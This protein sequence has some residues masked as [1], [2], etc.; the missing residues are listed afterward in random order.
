MGGL[1]ANSEVE[2]GCIPKTVGLLA[3]FLLVA[4]YVVAVLPRLSAGKM[5]VVA[6][7]FIGIGLAVPWIA[8]SNYQLLFDPIYPPVTFAA[9]YVGGTALAF[10][11]ALFGLE[12]E[13]WQVRASYDQKPYRRAVMETYGATCVA[14]PDYPTAAYTHGDPAGHHIRPIQHAVAGC[15]PAL[16]GTGIG[17]LEI[18][19]RDIDELAGRAPRH[20]QPGCHRY[21]R[22]SIQQ[23]NRC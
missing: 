14:S 11:C 9:I 18:D 4:A 3:M 17:H 12:C 21:Q 20:R 2:W 15:L 1:Y 19:R 13:I 16:G 5:A 22:Q 7:T 6:T 23:V 10:A 8:Y